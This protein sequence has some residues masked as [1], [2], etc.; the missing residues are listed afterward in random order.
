MSTAEA[1]FLFAGSLV[2]TV[3]SSAVLSRRI[4]QLG[5]WLL[6]S[7]SLLGILAALGADAPEIS[8]SLSAL[9]RGQ[10]DLGLGI[11]FG[12]NILNL[13]AL[14]GL[15][16]V[17]A[18]KVQVSRRTLYL[19]GGVAVGVMTLTTVE[20]YGILSPV[21]SVILIALIMSIY[22]TLTSASPALIQR[23][24][25]IVGL[26]GQLGQTVTDAN[27]DPE[28]AETPRRPS[29]ADILDVLPSLVCIILASVGLVRS[30]LVL[31]GAW[32]IPMAVLGTLILASLTSIPNVVTAV[33]L[34]LRARGSAV[35]S[36]SLNSNTLNLIAGVSLPALFFGRLSLNPRSVL[37]LWWLVGMTLLALGLSFIRGGLGR[38]SGVLL[39]I[40][41]IV[42]AFLMVFT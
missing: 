8:S 13:V 6:W 5:K 18:G 16:A 33:R 39:V 36:E 40:V 29:Y 25:R 42:F 26:G 3:T 31:G 21:M 19:N 15:S 20:L 17:L 9:R 24:A 38:K 11:V 7:E 28:K 30:A 35:L 2:L 1:A 32:K 37:S 23:A 10:H 27:R 22:V 41:Y 12:S 14:L 4:E 34:A